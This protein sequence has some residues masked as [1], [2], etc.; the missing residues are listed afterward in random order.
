VVTSDDRPGMITQVSAVIS[1]EDAN[2][3]HIE[4]GSNEST[5]AF[6]DVVLDIADVSH[7]NRIVTGLR[8]IPGVHEVQR[9]QKL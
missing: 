6:I 5:N 3:R 2:I 9:I 8:K 7:L 1:G 4:A